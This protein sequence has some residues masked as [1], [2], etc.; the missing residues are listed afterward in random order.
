M[1]SKF[2]IKNAKANQRKPVEYVLEIDFFVFSDMRGE[3]LDH[4]RRKAVR[5]AMPNMSDAKIT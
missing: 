4:L 5:K 3:A 2:Q 1:L